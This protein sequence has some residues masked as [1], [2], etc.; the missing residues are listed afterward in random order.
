MRVK[1]DF[2]KIKVNKKEYTFHNLILDTYLDLYARNNVEIIENAS[3]KAMN[4]CLLKF[5]NK[6]QFNESSKIS[7]HTF[8]IGLFNTSDLRTKLEVG[9]VITSENQIITNYDYTGDNCFK[10]NSSG[11]ESADL[12]DYINRKI[13]AI[14]FCSSLEEQDVF[15]ILDVSDCDITIMNNMKFEVKRRD[16]MEND[17]IFYS[18]NVQVTYPVHLSPCGIPSVYGSG[19]SDN[20]AT[21]YS[22]RIRI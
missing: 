2:V 15:S 11:T 14:A 8:N 9:D 16:I 18:E 10:F 7:N 6:I 22:I 13:T 19:Y 3:A 12:Q 5:D 17:M 1:N 20:N 21:I 4:Y